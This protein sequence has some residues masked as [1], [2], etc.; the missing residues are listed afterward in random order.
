[1]DETYGQFLDDVPVKNMV[2]FKRYVE[3]PKDIMT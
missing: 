3:V 2:M 1:M